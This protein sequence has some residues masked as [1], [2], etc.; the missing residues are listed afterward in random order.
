ME[1]SMPTSM[2]YEQKYDPDFPLVPGYN[3]GRTSIES[4]TVDRDTLRES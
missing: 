1:C 3:I 2:N 4:C